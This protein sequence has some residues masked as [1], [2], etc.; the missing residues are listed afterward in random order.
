MAATIAHEFNNVLMVIQSSSTLLA[1]ESV[2]PQ[3]ARNAA[4]RIA[5]AIKRGAR[6]TKDVT[7]F[8]RPAELALKAIAVKPWLQALVDDV[9]RTVGPKVTLDLALPAEDLTILGDP[10][11]LY[12][13]FSNLLVNAREAIPDQGRIMLSAEETT[14]GNQRQVSFSVRDTGSGIP[15]DTLERIFDPFFTTKRLGTGLGLAVS[16]QTILAHGGHIFAES[17]PSQGTTFH[18]LLPRA[19][20]DLQ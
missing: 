16:Q 10:E 3:M 17:V 19:S 7:R 2:S 5:Q 6:I 4:D 15:A 9:R 11:Q 20:E 8:A 13:V 1:R 18:V 14:T 12:Q